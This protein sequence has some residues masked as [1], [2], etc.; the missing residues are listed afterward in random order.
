MQQSFFAQRGAQQ[1]QWLPQ[2]KNRGPVA[3]I[4][5]ALAKCPDEYPSPA[6]SELPF[7]TDAAL[8]DSIRK[9]MSAATSSLHN[10]E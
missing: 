6:T 2:V 9:D 7:I 10:G 4:L 5:D 1:G 3:V 8:R